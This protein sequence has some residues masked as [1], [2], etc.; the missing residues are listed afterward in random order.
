MWRQWQRGADA[1][2][3]RDDLSAP[4]C[5]MMGV[6]SKASGI[7]SE[8]IG[9]SMVETSEGRQ[10]GVKL[11]KKLAGFI[12]GGGLGWMISAR[13]ISV[14]VAAGMVVGQGLRRLG[15]CDKEDVSGV[16]CRVWLWIRSRPLRI[17]G[18]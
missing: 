5:V 18:L 8:P 11:S 12:V 13:P 2:A 10:G 7:D 3:G 1:E 15:L 17:E 6:C 14:P 4:G 9:W 16:C